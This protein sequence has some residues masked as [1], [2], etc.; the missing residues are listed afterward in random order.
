MHNHLLEET[1][2][3]WERPQLSHSEVFAVCS[4]ERKEKVEY[5][6]YELLETD[7]R[8]QQKLF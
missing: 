7:F 8:D 3:K 5:R 6:F 1:V 2:K 4:R